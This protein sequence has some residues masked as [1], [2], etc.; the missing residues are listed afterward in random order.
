[1]YLVPSNIFSSAVPSRRA[2]LSKIH[3][4]YNLEKVLNFT[5]CLAKFLNSV[6]VLEQYFIS[7]L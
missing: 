7:L 1:M 6:S 3:G 5:S 2:H 4:S